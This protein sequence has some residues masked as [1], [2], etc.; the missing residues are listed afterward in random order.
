MKTVF[1]VAGGILLAFFALF[2]LN[3]AVAVA[4]AFGELLE[5]IFDDP[6]FQVF[7][8]LVLGGLVGI[9]IYWRR[10]TAPQR[11]L[12]LRKGPPTLSGVREG[13]SPDR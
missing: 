13:E 5:V 10:E 11:Q 12:E 6:G 7:A 8:L 2:V 4:P 3:I 9:F 1:Q